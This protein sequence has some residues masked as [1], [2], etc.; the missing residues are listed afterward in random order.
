MKAMDLFKKIRDTKGTF[1]KIFHFLLITLITFL[2]VAVFVR[3]TRNPER[4]VM[5]RDGGRGSQQG[6][7]ITTLQFCWGWRP[8][9]LLPGSA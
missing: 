6:A 5:A 8:R 7:Q 9:P 2:V 4:K 1:R 3:R